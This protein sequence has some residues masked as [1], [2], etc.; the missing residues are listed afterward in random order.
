R[1]AEHCLT[2]D[3][4]EARFVD[5]RREVVLV[6]QPERRVVLVGPAH[7]QL[8]CTAGVEARRP[9]IRVHCYLGLRRRLEDCGPFAVE[10]SKLD[11][12]FRPKTRSSS[13]PKNPLARL[14]L[15]ASPLL[16]IAKA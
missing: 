8:Q 6:R 14:L 16:G 5:E 4:L 7:R 1:L 13:R 2:G 11:N 15:P 9:R 12:A 3:L 10:E